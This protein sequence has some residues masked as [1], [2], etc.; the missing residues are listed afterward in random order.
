MWARIKRWLY[1][2]GRPGVLAR[3][4]NRAVAALHA[5][6]AGPASWITLEVAGR[7]SGRVI[8]F[9]LVMVTLDGQ[10]FLVSMLGKDA[11]WVRNVEAAGGVAVLRRNGAEAVRLAPL[12]VARRAPV[13]KA[14]LHAA[15]G[16]R[17][18]V[19]VDKD[20]PLAEFAAIAAGFPVFRVTHAAGS[21]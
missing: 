18:H 13:L 19:P 21:D 17:P 15:P 20:A 16:G 7:R 3:G 4:I 10:R 2:G 12:E 5:A 9:P 6:G 1:D 14:Y 8:A 11:A